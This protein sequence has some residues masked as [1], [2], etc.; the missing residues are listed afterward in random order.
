MVQLN[1]E[2]VQ[3][4]L[5][6]MQV[7]LLKVFALQLPEEY[8]KELRF[9]IARFLM[10]KARDRADKIWEEKGYDENTLKRIVNGDI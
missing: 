1:P 10:D 3:P 5:T 8:L 4:T 7:E 6:N 9:V 2:S